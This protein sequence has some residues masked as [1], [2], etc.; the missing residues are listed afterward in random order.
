MGTELSRR[1]GKGVLEDLFSK[2]T[3]LDL[4]EEEQKPLRDSQED[5]QLMVVRRIL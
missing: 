1:D 5:I 3:R 4:E 2:I